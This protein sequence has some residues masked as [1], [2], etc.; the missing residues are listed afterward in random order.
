MFAE[1]LTS[2]SYSVAGVYPA[3]TTYAQV[4]V[5]YSGDSSPGVDHSCTLEWFA[6]E[7]A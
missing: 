7:L 1:V 3:S 6:Y 5:E 2:S 4:Y